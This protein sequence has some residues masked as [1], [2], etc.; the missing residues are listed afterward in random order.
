MEISNEVKKNWKRILSWMWSKV[1][2][3]WDLIV[4]SG[5]KFVKE[6]FA[7]FLYKVA[8][9]IRKNFR[10]MVH[11]I[12][13]FLKAK[14]QALASYTKQKL[15]E[16][17]RYLRKKVVEGFRKSITKLREICRDMIQFIRTQVPI[18]VR[19][20]VRDFNNGFFPLAEALMIDLCRAGRQIFF[21]VAQFNVQL[22]VGVWNDIKDKVRRARDNVKAGLANLGS[23]IKDKLK[24]IAKRVGERAL[25]TAKRRILH[26]LWEWVKSDFHRLMKLIWD[27][28][29][30][31][32][33]VNFLRNKL[34]E[35]PQVRN[36]LEDIVNGV[37]VQV[38]L[39][40]VVILSVIASR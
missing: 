19:N 37:V 10:P 24:E 11:K 13:K 32:R 23:R 5:S 20:L 36:R 4:T 31:S 16:M 12:G 9:Y 7:P 40:V 6:N 35:H 8:K 30:F 33:L 39:I 28:R 17:H 21:M 38:S 27:N 15:K 25:Q 18:A 3:N 22:A 1:K 14:C 29:V 2:Q 26:P 34:N